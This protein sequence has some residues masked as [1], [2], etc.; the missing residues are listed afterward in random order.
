MSNAVF[1]TLPGLIF[2]IKKRPN[3]STD[4][5]RSVSG[6]EVAA[7]FMSYPIWDWE[8]SFEILRETAS[9]FQSLAGFFLARQGRYDSFL[10]NDA[11]DN[12]A[13]LQGFGTGNGATTAFQLAR[14]LGGFSEPVYD[15]NG[16]PSIYVAG[17]LKAAGVDYTINS[18]GVVTF[19]TAPTAGQA[20]TWSGAY[21]WRVRFAEDGSDFENF[22][23]KLWSAGKVSFS[24]ARL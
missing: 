1:P 21:Y 5:Q 16:A 22:M 4:V 13:A 6:R 3:F 14:A 7:A 18:T 2:P 24:T 17:T 15:L 9:E 23:V 8:L 11:S 19:S 20:L 12:T 10:F